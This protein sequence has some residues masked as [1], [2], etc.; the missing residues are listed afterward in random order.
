MFGCADSNANV[1]TQA[2]SVFN[3]TSSA[4]K[5]FPVLKMF[6]LLAGQMGIYEG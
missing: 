2:A 4:H 5:H 3:N 6:T 1:I